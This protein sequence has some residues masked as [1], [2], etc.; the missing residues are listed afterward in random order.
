LT[1]SVLSP[2][3]THKA[4][5]MNIPLNTDEPVHISVDIVI[6]PLLKD[7][8]F[9]GKP[10]MPAVESICLLAAS[11]K[12]LRPEADISTMIDA[13]FNKFLY[14]SPD[15]RRI[16][17]VVAV[18]LT[19][20]GDFAAD[21]LTKIKS[22]STAITRTREHAGITFSQKKTKKN[23]AL[24]FKPTDVWKEE[25][26]NISAYQI[27]RE[28]VPFGPAFQNISDDLKLSAGGAMAHIHTPP[29]SLSRP[30]LLGSPF[31]LDA[32]FHAACVWSQRYRQIVA[33]PVGFKKRMV[34]QKTRPDNDY[35]ARIVPVSVDQG[36]LVF[37]IWIFDKEERLFEA[38]R[39]V[40]MRDVSGGRLKP[41]AWLM[42]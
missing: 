15:A 37:D 40:K 38:V 2:F 22:K 20:R 17:A 25:G 27:Y 1:G 34:C 3:F 31:T 32:A 7:H 33:F 9:Q 26:I 29:E 5:I 35:M 16:K 11:V 12:R 30:S 4:V 8:H 23:Q 39:G 14:L 24:P 13:R 28:L 36:P 18:G 6:N 21:L 41:P 42:E 10:V 19:D